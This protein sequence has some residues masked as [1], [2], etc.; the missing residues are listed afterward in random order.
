MT[1]PTAGTHPV[2]SA[3]GNKG[4][5]GMM[6]EEDTSSRSE[7]SDPSEPKSEGADLAKA[8]PN[9]ASSPE[10]ARVAN[11]DGDSLNPVGA[12]PEAANSSA[13]NLATRPAP[14]AQDAAA[15]SP[16]GAVTGALAGAT[17]ANPAADKTSGSTPPWLPDPSADP[18]QLSSRLSGPEPNSTHVDPR[19]NPAD[20]DPARGW[21]A[22]NGSS[23]SAGAAK[24]SFARQANQD[25]V[26]DYSR[27]VVQQDMDKVNEPKALITSTA[28]DAPGQASAMYTNEEAGNHIR[29]AAPG[30]AV[31]Q[32]YRDSKDD[33][34]SPAETKNAMTAEI[35]RQGP[36]NVSKHSA[37]P[38][39]VNVIDISPKSLKN[40]QNFIQQLRNDPRVQRVIDP[41]QNDPAIHI[42]IAQPPP[43]DPGTP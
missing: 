21:E 27:R 30:R 5:R 8:D 32:V 40:P 16:T 3:L 42:E 37:D 19:A 7:T 20:F 10:P 43:A 24:L 25:V 9:P 33:D 26:S 23:S 12:A 11:H 18:G 22:P 31:L 28:R 6:E 2:T 1:S 35:N 15:P 4:K 36:A 41:S 14:A 38:T 29:Y 34:L 13:E 17:P 39:T